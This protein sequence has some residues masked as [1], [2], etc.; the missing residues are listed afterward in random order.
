MKIT[1]LL[2]AALAGILYFLVDGFTAPVMPDEIGYLAIARYLVDGQQLNLSLVALYSFG[3]SLLIAPIDWFAQQPDLIYQLSLLISIVSTA[4]VPVL[5]VSIAKRLGHAP[6]WEVVFS[7]IIVSVFPAYFFQN[8][9]IWPE[10]TFRLFFLVTVYVFASAWVTGRWQ[11]WLVLPVCVEWLFALH[12][13]AL[14]IIPVTALFILWG[15][16]KGQAGKLT[17]AVALAILVG[18]HMAVREADG[19]FQMALW[20]YR[21]A[22][23]ERAAAFAAML[24]SLPGIKNAVA[25]A[26]GQAWAAVV[27]SFGFVAIGVY[28]A[29]LAVVRRTLPKDIVLF[30]L[31]ASGAVFAASVMQ[32]MQFT[33]I[34]H[35]IYE[36]YVDG[37]TTPFAFAGL[38]ICLRA[39]Q[40]RDIPAVSIV[41]VV[42]PMAIALYGFRHAQLV[43][44]GI[45]TVS[46]L[47]WINQIIDQ[48]DLTL[49]HL[50]VVCS[51][52]SLSVFLAFYTFALN[53]VAALAGLSLV[54]VVLD[55]TIYRSAVAMQT[56]HQ[57]VLAISQNVYS[58]GTFQDVHW[59]YSA[60]AS[61]NT[62]IDQFATVNRQMPTSVIASEDI[63]VG[64]AAVVGGSFSKDGYFCIGVF[65]DGTKLLVR[66]LD[67]D[68][69]PSCP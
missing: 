13:R 24:G 7:A 52:L 38:I 44:V 42:V 30:A 34:D 39:A 15:A 56:F 64:D 20:Q 31:L 17:A 28:G 35:V 9:L 48:S 14:G 6:S 63:P 66:G 10:A 49:T 43:G 62:L 45:P 61:G 55:A 26:A 3:Q 11:Y 51:L 22:G 27:A 33:R 50:L 12:P 47:T 18:M 41:A 46:G 16:Y 69:D 32:M 53:K 19:H 1:L 54:V 60:S 21:S 8:F 40:R 36:R 59:D 4:L 67:P 2:A 25:V 23:G 68:G 58:K 5:L 29:L 57:D 65:R 37:V